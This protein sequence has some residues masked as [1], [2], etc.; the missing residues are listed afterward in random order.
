[1]ATIVPKSDIYVLNHCAKYLARDYHA[2]ARHDYGP[3][4]ASDPRA[5]IAEAWR[6][7]VIDGYSEGGDSI[8]GYDRNEVTFVYFDPQSAKIPEKVGVIGTFANLYEP[9]ALR[10]VADFPYFTATAVVPKGEVHTYRYVVDGTSVVDPINPQLVTL[11]NGAVWSRFFTQGCTQPIT[12]E[13]SAMTI[14]QRFTAHILPFRS[15]SGQNFLNRYYENL[16]HDNRDMR[17]PNAYRLDE[18]VGAANYIDKVVAREEIHHLVDYQTCLPI[19]DRVLRLRDPFQDPAVMPSGIYVALYGEMENHQ[20]GAREIAGWDYDRYADPRYFL[21]LL[22]RHTL[23]GAF[24]HPKYG[25]NVGAA[26]WAYLEE[27]YRDANGRTLF[28]WRVNQEPP[29]G[30]SADYRG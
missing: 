6:F 19:I 7:P 12:F 29:L 21:E 2:A 26:G 14:L 30:T 15:E 24:A 20:P 23:T 4:P 11:D 18:S 9:I 10:R 22:R 27:R 16:D 25:G 3:F 8:A 28:D 17:Y 1:V 5:Q 13:R